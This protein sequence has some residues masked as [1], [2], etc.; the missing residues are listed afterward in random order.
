MNSIGT[1]QLLQDPD[2]A[3]V[4][5]N[6]PSALAQSLALRSAA[7][8]VVFALIGVL[9]FCFGVGLSAI[10]D[11]P[12]AAVLFRNNLILLLIAVSLAAALTGLVSMAVRSHQL[13]RHVAT[14]RLE[15]LEVEKRRSAELHSE[16]RTRSELLGMMSHELRSSVQV[17]VASADL[18]GLPVPNDQR[19]QAALRIQR[20]SYAL[21]AR[22]LDLLT[23]TRGEAAKLEIVPQS[24]EARVLAE[25]VVESVDAATAAEKGLTVRTMLPASPIFAMADASR[26]SQ[27]LLNLLSNAVKYTQH[28]H[29]ILELEP[30]P[31]TSDRLVFHV[32]DTGPGI[33]PWQLDKA[34]QPFERVGVIDTAEE[35][36]GV[37]LAIVRTLVELLGATINVDSS[38]GRGTCV[39]VCVPVVL[40]NPDALHGQMESSDGV[41]IVSPESLVRQELEA[42]VARVN[43]SYKTAASAGSALNYL[44]S[45]RYQ[46]VIVDLDL[47]G[48]EASRLVSNTRRM[49]GPS[50]DAYFVAIGE[51]GIGDE[52]LTKSFDCVLEKPIE[53]PT[54]EGVLARSSSELKR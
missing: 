54:M 52:I 37:G 49:G 46:T 2:A 33:A 6:L 25:S 18:L 31:P 13:L 9:L 20:A 42:M 1:N 5:S 14:G 27:I 16:A 28:G 26:I 21:S 32:K 19:E 3:I 29:V 11:A 47:L 22:L 40:E 50:D 48:Q 51:H 10:F 4:N 44:A 30:A 35:S 17:I 15:A 43:R 36:T 24:F 8:F 45:R 12:S 39:T 41:L 23:L 7:L 53:G 38:V 34:F